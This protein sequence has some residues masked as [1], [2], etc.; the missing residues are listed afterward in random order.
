MG[1]RGLE[2]LYGV[3]AAS[4]TVSMVGATVSVWVLL[5]RLRR[6]FLA[7]VS[8]AAVLLQELHGHEHTHSG[9]AAA[10]ATTTVSV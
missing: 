4:T 3:D 8:V 6:A 7:L 2:G 9:D 1:V 5:S 10:A